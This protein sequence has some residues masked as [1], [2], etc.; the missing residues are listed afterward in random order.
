MKPQVDIERR[1]VVWRKGQ[2]TVIEFTEDEVTEFLAALRKAN[3]AHRP[4]LS[5]AERDTAMVVSSAYED[6]HD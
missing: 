6:N 1:V 3:W 2:D 4:K 5:Q